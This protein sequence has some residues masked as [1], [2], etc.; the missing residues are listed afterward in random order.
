M[1]DTPYI[2]GEVLT[3]FFENP[4]TSI[5]LCSFALSNRIAWMWIMRLL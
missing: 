4:Q 5:K 3:T 1:S 2:V